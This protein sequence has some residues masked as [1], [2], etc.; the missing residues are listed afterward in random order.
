MRRF[1]IFTASLLFLAWTATASAIT[2]YDGTLGTLPAAQPTPG[3]GWAYGASGAAT[4]TA[5]G[6]VTTLDTTAADS[7]SAGYNAHLVG[8]ISGNPATYTMTGLPVPFDRST[9]Y[10]VEITTQVNSESHGTHT[11][12]AGFS[13]IVLSS[14]LNGIELGLWTNEIWAQSISAGP[15]YFTHGEGAA[16]PPTTQH[17]YDLAI[18]GGQYRLFSDGTQILSGNLR[19][20]SGSL[21]NTT[22]GAF[23]TFPYATPNYIFLGD[24]TTEAN[25]SVNIAD[26]RMFSTA[27]PEPASFVLMGLGVLVC[28]GIAY[29]HRRKPPLN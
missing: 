19:D 13:I 15:T 21:K 16:Y 17:Q 20:Y 29:R 23:S 1:T 14:D 9:G 11:D 22:V 4:Q 27:L 18:L 5:A 25:A 24:D 7:I 12:R 2:L 6:G 28:G 8:T 3:Q 26:V 10:T